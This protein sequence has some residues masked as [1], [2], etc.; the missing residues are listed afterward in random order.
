MLPRKRIQKV[1]FAMVLLPQGIRWVRNF[2]LVSY[3]KFLMR[4]SLVLGTKSVLVNRKSQ[5]PRRKQTAKITQEERKHTREHSN[6][7]EGK[8][9]I[10]ERGTRK[11][12]RCKRSCITCEVKNCG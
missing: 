6:N 9:S 2:S 4:F 5:Q 8:K 11:G 3:V 1:G 12:M 7:K 10:V